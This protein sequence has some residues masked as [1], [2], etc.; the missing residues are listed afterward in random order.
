TGDTKPNKY[1]IYQANGVDLLIHEMTTSPLVW[2]EKFT[3]LKPGDPG[4][5]TAYSA[6]TAVQ[7]SSHTVDKAFG[8]VLNQIATPPSKA[9][10]LAIATH[11]PASDDTIGPSLQNVRAWY[12]QGS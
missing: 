4:W 7:E 12:P 11:F 10:R 5:D 3:G 1:L 2:T 8:Y 9:P 6:N